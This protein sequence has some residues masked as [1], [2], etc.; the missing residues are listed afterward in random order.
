[1]DAEA[2]KY[3][4][5]LEGVTVSEAYLDALKDL[6]RG[7]T[8]GRVLKEHRRKRTVEIA[9]GGRTFLVKIYKRERGLRALKAL[10]FG[11]KAG[12]ELRNNAE[13]LRRGI[14]VVPLAAVKDQGGEH[15]VAT[16][17]LSDWAELQQVLLSDETDARRRRT[18]L[19]QYGKFA[20]RLQDAGVWQYDFNPTNILVREEE[21]RLIDFEWIRMKRGPLG[22]SAR[23]VLV[24][25]MNRIPKLSRPDRLR[26]L[27]GYVASDPREQ[28]RIKEIARELLRLA[29]EKIAR[30]DDREER[31][32][33]EDNRDFGLFEFGEVRGHY[34]KARG[35]EPGLSIE[36]MK[37][38]AESGG[39][40]FPSTEEADAV[41]A[42]RRANREARQGGP[43]PLG[44]LVRGNGPAGTLVFPR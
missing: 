17:K 15:W 9:A 25:K 1:M 40:G 28:G 11:T 7:V 3:L 41:G 4:K 35:S 5:T 22:R 26:F 13:L 24:A 30:D 32:C 23:M 6:E 12:R 38:I 27:K 10:L 31:R 20:R 43:R 36:E 19:F 21:F 37:T 29:A 16:E 33:L 39:E 8:S 14:P 34:R 18:L 44:V 2:P 42:W